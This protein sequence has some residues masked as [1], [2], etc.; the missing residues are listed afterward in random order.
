MAMP[1]YNDYV[2]IIDVKEGLQ[3]GSFTPYVGIPNE[4]GEYY[5]SFGEVLN[6]DLSTVTRTR[7]Y[8]VDTGYWFKVLTFKNNI[9]MYASFWEEA[10]GTVNVAGVVYNEQTNTVIAKQTEG[11]YPNEV[12]MLGSA[13]FGSPT[14]A[15]AHNYGARIYAE[16]NY[17]NANT[18]PTEL[19]TAMTS[20]VIYVQL[21]C[22][23]GDAVNPLININSD[24][25]VS[26]SDLIRSDDNVNYCAKTILGVSD[27]NGLHD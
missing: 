21:P 13:F 4:G 26:Y 25:L 10:N 1:L 8:D 12:G 6:V 20:F 3:I 22:I 15:L 18:P 27:M 17:Y 23:K 16:S 19:V 24:T 14:I 2:K 5:E 11:S 9:S 7:N